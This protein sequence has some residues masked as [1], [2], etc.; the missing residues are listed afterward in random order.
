MPFLLFLLSVATLVAVSSKSNAKGPNGRTQTFTLDA[1]MPDAL[2]NQVLAALVSGADPATL[3]AFALAIQAKYPLSAGLLHAKA[4]TLRG[5]LSASPSLPMPMPDPGGPP[6]DASM[7]PSMAAFI[8]AELANETDPAKLLALASTIAAQ[9]PAAA[10][11]LTQRAAVLN[12]QQPAQPSPVIIPPAPQPT[13]SNPAPPALNMPGLDPGMPPDLAQAVITAL[14]TET[15]PAKLQGEAQEIGGSYPLAAGLLIAKANTL[16][17]L[18]S[19]SGVP[20]GSQL[21]LDPNMPPATVQLVLT[22]LATEGEPTKL[23]TLADQLTPQY[24]IAAGLLRTR[25]NVILATRPPIQIVPDPSATNVTSTYAVKSGDYPWKIA[26]QYTGHGAR[27]PELVAANPQ[28]PRAKDGNF[29]SLLPGEKLTLPGSWVTPAAPSAPP[30]AVASNPTPP[31]LSATTLPVIAPAP[32]LPALDTNI[33]ANVAS[34]VHNALQTATDPNQ[35]LGF[36][37]AIAP[38]YPAAA[39]LLHAKAG[40]LSAPAQASGPAATYR[41]KPGDS[42]AKI[43]AALVHKG[44]RWKE[45]VSANPQKKLAPNGNFA[46]LVPGELLQLPPSWTSNTAA[47]PGRA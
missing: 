18:Q 1:G 9:Y 46:T 27:W 7:P 38:R 2:R 43:A 24:P 31:D 8:H 23:Q 47:T 20:S 22:E 16:L 17:A 11:L 44:S 12:V 36:A 32:P 41:V 45:L 39:G 6:L 40:A 25:A 30:V 33:P 15:N 37:S 21:G 29:A 19:P 26:T 14:S 35:V 10:D 13:P 42:P 3:D 5:G 4:T 34:A 28:K